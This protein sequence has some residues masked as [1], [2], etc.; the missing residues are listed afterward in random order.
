MEQNPSMP[1]ARYKEGWPIAKALV[2]SVEWIDHS[3]NDFEHYNVVYSYSVNDE[4]YSGDFKDYRSPSD[5][6]LHRNDSIDIQYDPE[7]PERSHYPLVKSA[8]N[9]RLTFISIGIAV[10]AIVLL[11]V[12]LN[13]GFK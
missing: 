6:Y 3:R 13:D 5:D 12:Y 11:I 9:R 7:H 1:R 4:M 2:Y 10:A 8:T